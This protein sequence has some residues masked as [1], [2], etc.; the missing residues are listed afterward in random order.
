MNVLNQIHV[1]SLDLQIS[2]FNKHKKTV[3]FIYIG[4]IIL[5]MLFCNLLKKSQNQNEFV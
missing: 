2:I 4:R 1:K 3:I 5:D